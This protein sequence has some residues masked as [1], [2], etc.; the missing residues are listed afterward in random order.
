MQSAGIK[1]RQ[2]MKNSMH[3]HFY[4]LLIAEQVPKIILTSSEILDT[5]LSQWTCF[6]VTHTSLL[7][8]RGSREKENPICQNVASTP[9]QGNF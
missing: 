9:G 3:R 4:W 7:N 2:A 1:N 5:S 6:R 8:F